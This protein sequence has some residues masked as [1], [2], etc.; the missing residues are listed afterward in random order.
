[1]KDSSKGDNTQQ[2]ALG[3]DS[4]EKYDSDS[5][6]DKEERKYW[7]WVKRLNPFRQGKIPPVPE[8]DAGLV[9]ETQAGWFS[10]LTWGWMTPLM[11][12]FRSCVEAKAG[13]RRGIGVLCNRRISGVLIKI[14]C[15][16]HSQTS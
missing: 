3:E 13:F 12:V 8:H 15:P 16:E 6:C 4:K 11:T 14:S 1:M 5:I 7:T 9:P 2:S 10:R